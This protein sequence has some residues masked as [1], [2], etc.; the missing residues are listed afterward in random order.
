MFLIKRLFFAY[1]SLIALAVAAYGVSRFYAP[2]RDPRTMFTIYTSTIRSLDPT[3]IADAGTSDIMGHVYE[4]LYNYRYGGKADELFPQVA[5][6]FPKI[7]ADRLTYTFPLRR[8]I[9]FYDPKKIVW[10]DGVGPE[11]TA[12]DVIY[13]WKRMADFH[14]AAPSYSTVLQDNIVGLDAFRD[15]SEKADVVDYDRPVEG[16]VA[17]D[18]H[19][20][21]VKLTK[22][23]PNFLQ[24]TAYLGVAVTS[25]QAVE[26]LNSLG[27]DGMK[28]NPIATGPY[29]VGEYLNDQRLVLVR[30]PVYRGRPDVDG[31]TGKLLPGDQRLP[32]I[33]RIQFDY[34]AELLPSWYLFL[35]KR[36]DIMSIPKETY[37]DAVIGGQIN[38]ELAKKGIVLKKRADP[39]LYYVQFN[40]TD[41]VIGGNRP[42]RQAMSLALDRE[43]FI[44]VYR[45]GRG[46]PGVSIFPP[47]ASLWDPNYASKWCHF[48]VEAARAKLREAEAIQG[49]KIPTLHIQMG[50][51][52]TDDRQNAEFFCRSWHEI[53]LEVTPEYNTY[54][55]YLE[56]LDAK[57]YQITYTGWVPDY[58]DE[59]TYLR[60]F[61]AT[62]VK[63][64]GSNTAG[65]VNEAYQKLLEASLSLPRSPER[66]VLYRKMRDILDDDLPE[67]PLFYPQIHALRYDWMGG[68][69]DPLFTQGFYAYQT[70][71]V[72][73]RRR[74][75]LGG[76]AP[77][78][79]G[80]N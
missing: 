2:P 12:Q 53:G 25:R 66:D 55:H 57:S 49:G 41:P 51:A 39:G 77:A 23:I 36:Y 18:D 50:G 21:Q 40:M 46:T 61:D 28:E 79:Q 34:A 64:P 54:A 62:L 37:R 7:S 26:K 42:L 48:D 44:R 9:L 24:L 69:K 71:D 68:Y 11:V 76:G 74:A 33:Q 20:L 19:T 56:L 5:A 45:S 3:I 63:P 4:C 10:P 13:S 43:K 35:Q 59:K 30:N 15:Y 58:P 67:T 70:L 14:S 73:M 29:A 22:P 31:P 72:E 27:L 78:T 75:T 47:D 65:Y 32:Q 17:V 38:P 52:E 8:G 80:G 1:L 16:L 6:D 60:L